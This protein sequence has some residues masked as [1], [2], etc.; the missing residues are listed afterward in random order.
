[1]AKTMKISISLPLGEFRLIES[2]RRQSHLSRSK[3]LL[4]A[5]HTWL[6]VRKTEELERQYVEGYQKHPEKLAEVEGLFRAG[7]A[8]FEP[9]ETW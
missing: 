6:K 5:I 3:I 1:M 7:L 9:E 4:D 2:V 8:S